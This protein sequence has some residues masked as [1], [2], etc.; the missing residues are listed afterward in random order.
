MRCLYALIVT[1][2]LLSA[3]GD[4]RV[5]EEYHDFEEPYWLVSET[6]EFEFEIRQPADKYDLYCNI[7]NSISYPYARLFVTYYLQDSSGNVLQKDLINQFLFDEKSGKPFGTS[8][9]GDLYDHQF[10][11]L[12]GYEFKYQGKYK[13]KFEQFMRT[14]T[15]QGVMAV[16]LKIEQAGKEK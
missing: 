14:D 4:A 13:M 5:Y 8:G 9:L 7:R 2:L 12:K 10:L 15:L 6:P 16:G 1:A 3:C 11:L